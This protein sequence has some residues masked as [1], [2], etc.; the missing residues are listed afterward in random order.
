MITAT[1]MVDGG[2]WEGTLEDG[3]VG[4]FPTNYT[5]TE[6]P[7]ASAPT[8]ASPKVITLRAKTTDH[9]TVLAKLCATETTLS[10]ELF[11]T[12][13]TI[14]TP[15]KDVRS[16]TGPQK[17][18][19]DVR[20]LIRAHDSF[21]TALKKCI[22]NDAATVASVVIRHA[23]A[24]YSASLYFAASLSRAL[25]TAECG[26]PE[27]EAILKRA[28]DLSFAERFSVPIARLQSV[29]DIL[30]DACDIHGSEGGMVE[31]VA[32]DILM[33]VAHSVFFSLCRA[34]N[35]ISDSHRSHTSDESATVCNGY[36]TSADSPRGHSRFYS[37]AAPDHP[38]CSTS[39]SGTLPLRN[40]TW[41]L[42]D[43]RPLKIC[44]APGAQQGGGEMIADD[45]LPT[46]RKWRFRIRGSSASTGAKRDRKP[47][48]TV[49]NTGPAAAAS[50]AA[51]ALRA[52]F[53]EVRAADVSI[54]HPDPTANSLFA[55]LDSYAK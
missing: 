7:S 10:S 2:W 6:T 35:M 27:I 32:A 44:T 33:K 5:T 45:E 39:S 36:S 29:L 51:T 12:Q 21:A 30:D 17:A 23:P 37:P 9:A 52:E 11:D 3:T 34:C 16:L 48:A 49:G 18:A 46:A 20:K 1:S 55:L 25:T 54:L 38:Q 13:M 41:S 50:A 31:N 53:S 26:K 4:W 22:T 8:P 15:L 40:S 24:V 14:C 19:V 42:L 47:T 43:V 28:G